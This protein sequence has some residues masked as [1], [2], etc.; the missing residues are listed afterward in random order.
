MKIEIYDHDETG[1]QFLADTVEV[2]QAE[3]VF[4][5][6]DGKS[7]DLGWLLKQAEAFDQE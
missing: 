2:S 1:R 3:N 6:M 5:K 4:L 7:Y